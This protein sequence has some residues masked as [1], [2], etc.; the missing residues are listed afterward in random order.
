MGLPTVFAG[1][2]AKGSGTVLNL[3]NRSHTAPFTAVSR[4]IIIDSEYLFHSASCMLKTNKT[5]D[6]FYHKLYSA[7][8]SPSQATTMTTEMQVQMSALSSNNLQ[9][10][11]L[12]KPK[13]H[14]TY[15]IFA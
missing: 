7:M 5:N 10:S 1:R 13:T 4:F 2:V 8:M 6:P 9:P 3:G 14:V 15:A 12:P 11:L